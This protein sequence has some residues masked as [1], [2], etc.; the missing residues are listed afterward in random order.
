MPRHQAL[1]PPALEALDQ[2]H[3]ASRCQPDSVQIKQSPRGG[4]DSKSQSL[5]TKRLKAS[6]NLEPKQMQ[7][8]Q[9]LKHHVCQRLNQK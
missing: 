3:T 7:R 1:F 2:A 6:P 9:K 4:L 5:K 8:Q